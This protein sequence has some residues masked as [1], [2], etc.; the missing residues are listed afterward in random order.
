MNIEVLKHSSIKLTGSKIIYFDPFQIETNLN[1]ADYI[2]ITHDHYDHYDEKAIE[3][4]MNEKTI[5]IVP[6]CLEERV[7]MI[8]DKVLVVEPQNTY[9]I[10]DITFTTIPSYNIN[11]LYH[12]KENGYVGYNVLIDGIS[13]Y[14]MGDTDHTIESNQV[15]TDICFVPIGGTY[16]MNV[17]EAAAYINS[18]KVIKVIPIHYGSIVGDRNLALKF[19]QLVNKDIEVEIL[20]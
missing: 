9:N 7:R 20:I 1:D 15:K 17:E 6:T 8:S 10:D 16:T 4:V 2:F 11:S 13:Y 3:M 19:R 14:I 12:P 5:L 18:L